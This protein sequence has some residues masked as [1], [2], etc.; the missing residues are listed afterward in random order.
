[1]ATVIT[2]VQSA[3]VPVVQVAV[4][5]MQGPSAMAIGPTNTLTPGTPGLWIETGLGPDGD[6]FTFWLEDG[7]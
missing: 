2:V 5:G 1:M 3:A 4:P 7:N 6:D